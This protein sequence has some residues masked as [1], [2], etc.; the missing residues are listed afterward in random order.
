MTK[1]YMNAVIIESFTFYSRGAQS[2]LL[3]GIAN[4][5]EMKYGCGVG[6]CGICKLRLISGCTG[7]LLKS[8]TEKYLYAKKNG[9]I[10]PC[11]TYPK[12]DIVLSYI[13]P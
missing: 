3:A 12:S 1:I 13:K 7:S 11:V 4:N 8:D 10:L 5:I 9:F 6:K 2:I